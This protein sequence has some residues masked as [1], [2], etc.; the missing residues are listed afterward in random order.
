[1]SDSRFTIYFEDGW[2]RRVFSDRP[3]SN[4]DVKHQIKD[5]PENDKPGP[6][7][8]NKWIVTWKRGGLIGS[9]WISGLK[10]EYPED[11]EVDELPAADS[12][13]PEKKSRSD[14]TLESLLATKVSDHTPHRCVLKEKPDTI[15]A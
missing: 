12:E 14:S 1:M 10:V 6:P 9:K 13:S 8:T 3:G 7:N 4:G 15:L 2:W 11:E 5:A